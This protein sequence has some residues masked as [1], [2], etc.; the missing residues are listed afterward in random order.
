MNLTVWSFLLEALV[1]IQTVLLARK[2]WYAWLVALVSNALWGLYGWRTG[3]WGFV[4]A[5][6]IYLPIYVYG[7]VRWHAQRGST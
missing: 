6:V 7:L 4:A 3:Q 5:G 1:I 2:R